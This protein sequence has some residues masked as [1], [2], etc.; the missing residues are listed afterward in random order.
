VIHPPLITAAAIEARLQDLAADITTHYHGRPLTVIGLLNG[1]IF[2]LV[3]L[4]RLLPL[5]T[6]LECWR[7]QSY[8]G[9]ASTGTLQGLDQCQASLAGR[10]VLLLD[11]ILDTG[12][13][14]QSVHAH[15]LALGAATVNI[16]VLLRKNKPRPIE[17]TPRWVGFEIE[18]E[19][20]I[21][22]GLDFNGE[23]RGLRAIH[24]L[25]PHTAPDRTKH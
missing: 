14:L 7:V 20:V 15:A 21:G 3:D 12:L 17:I 22:Y 10:E 2:F 6:Q 13:T 16:A 18:D 1:S 23:Y 5:S 19:F 25:D 9:S 4:F 11:D 8:Q 24:V